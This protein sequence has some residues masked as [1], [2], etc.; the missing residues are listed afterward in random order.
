MSRMN[1]ENWEVYAI[2]RETGG[3]A[4]AERYRHKVNARKRYLP[5]RRESKWQIVKDYGID[6]YLSKRF[7][8]GPVDPADLEA[9][10]Y[11]EPIYAAYDCTGCM[12]TSWIACFKVPG[13]VWCYHR[14]ACDI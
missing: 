7:F 4:A 10:Y 9:R 13:G 6:G 5:E 2:M 8:P 11:I 1:R 12:F 3:P 14:I